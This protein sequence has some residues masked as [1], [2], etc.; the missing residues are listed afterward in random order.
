M[1]QRQ[2]I[3]FLLLILSGI[4]FLCGQEVVEEIVA[5][6]NDDIITLS[7]YKAEHDAVYR[8]LSADYQGE[9]FEKA[10]AQM[11]EVLL[12]N[13][14]TNIL[15]LQEAGK[16]D[17]PVEEEL[18]TQLENIK[19]ENNMA[20]DQDLIR[21]LQ[22]EGMTFEGLKKQLRDRILREGI[23]Y[24]QV[25]GSIVIDDAEIVNYHKLHPEEFTILPEYKLRGIYIS[26][27]LRSE[28]EVEAKKREISEKLAS[29][30]EFAALAG[31]YTEDATKEKQGDM[32]R[33]KKGQL[34]KSLEQ[35]V[36][37][38]KEGEVAPWLKVINGW[39]L[40]RVDEKKESRIKTFEES[41]D[42]L[43]Q[44]LFNEKR[45]KK[46]EEFLRDL[47]EKSYIKILKPNPLDY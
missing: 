36:E 30:E 33:Y 9:A 26:A 42:E 31:E 43:Q 14:I 3:F 19:K 24:Q 23:I 28:E 18:K 27:E 22:Q 40:L 2:A 37:K 39:Y 29:G 20:S 17:F 13:I 8:M 11:K 4:L 16:M 5:I 32:G 41:R 38:L 34:A 15:L 21:A 35:A 10:Y 6:V 44:K 45:Q 46:T 12:P 47:R 25:M 7:Q 1:K